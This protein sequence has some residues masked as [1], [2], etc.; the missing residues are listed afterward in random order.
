MY[1]ALQKVDGISWKIIKAKFFACLKIHD[2]KS[3]HIEVKCTAAV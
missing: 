1:V 3:L 2:D